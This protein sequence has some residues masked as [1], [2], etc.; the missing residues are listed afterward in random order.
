MKG[1]IVCLNKKSLWNVYKYMKI[2]GAREGDLAAVKA[3]FK[4]EPCRKR[5]K[6]SLSSNG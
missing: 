3:C 2:I 1:N 4:K 6:M 5:R